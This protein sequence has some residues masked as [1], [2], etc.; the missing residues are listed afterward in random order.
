MMY[1]EAHLVDVAKHFLVLAQGLRELAIVL[2]GLVDVLL[3][4]NVLV[5]AV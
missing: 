5:D 3:H 2:L 4:Q 1:L